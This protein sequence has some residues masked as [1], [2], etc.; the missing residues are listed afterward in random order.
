[1]LE[2]QELLV[3]GGYIVP[4]ELN[5]FDENN[6]ENRMQRAADI[7]YEYVL[8]LSP[9]MLSPQH[10]AF[11]EAVSDNK[12]QTASLEEKHVN[13]S[14]GTLSGTLVGLAHQA[15]S[16]RRD[17]KANDYPSEFYD[18]YLNPEDFVLTGGPFQMDA[19]KNPLKFTK[20]P[21]VRMERSY[22]NAWTTFQ[23]QTKNFLHLI[24][25]GVSEEKVDVG[26]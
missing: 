24:A 25:K 26:A 23:N 1:M 12:S 21:F 3:K 18:R 9:E 10:R 17:A 19:E 11:F 4:D 7:F 22:L 15:Q 2:L 20:T 13:L 8:N 6:L 16:F 5:R 14:L